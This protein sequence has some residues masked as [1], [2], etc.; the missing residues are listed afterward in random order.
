MSPLEESA[1]G[2]P[3]SVSPGTKVPTVTPQTS[4]GTRTPSASGEPQNNNAKKD[5]TLVRRPACENVATIT[6]RDEH[7]VSYP[8]DRQ[9]S[10]YARALAEYPVPIRRH[11]CFWA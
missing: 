11:K 7:P 9:R 4:R 5:R 1:R 2:D 8:R 10:P 3:P 6:K